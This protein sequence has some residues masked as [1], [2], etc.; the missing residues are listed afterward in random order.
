MYRIEADLHTHTLASDHAYSTIMELVAE[1]ARKGLKG[2][3][4]TDHGPALPDAPCMM[5]FGNL[6]S[7]PRMMNGVLT[8]RG[9]EANLIDYEGNL[10]IPQNILSALDWVIVSI[11]TDC[12]KAATVEEHTRGWMKVMSNPWVDVIGHSG[13]GDYM[14][15]YEPVIIE[16]GKSNKIIEINNLSFSARPGSVKNCPVIA[17][18]C[19]QYRVPVVVSSDAHVAAQV[20]EFDTALQMLKEIDFPEELILNSSI[21]RLVNYINQKRTHKIIL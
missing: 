14:Y 1:A 17:R 13:L 15:D 2:I 6:K 8:L 10:D 9:V 3:A 7:I 12:I 19:K 5:H 4:V 18:L 11:H 16:A 20:G 21:D